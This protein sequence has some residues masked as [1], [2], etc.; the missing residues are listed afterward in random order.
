MQNGIIFHK[1]K[2][3]DHG[4]GAWVCESVSIVIPDLGRRAKD[5]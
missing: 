4:I 5:L 1:R 2:G 3:L